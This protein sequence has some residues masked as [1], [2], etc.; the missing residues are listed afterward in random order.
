D[1][2]ALRTAARSAF[3]RADHAG[4]AARHS[5]RIRAAVCA[6]SGTHRTGHR[7]KAAPG[8]KGRTETRN[9]AAASASPAVRPA[10]AQAAR[11]PERQEEAALG[12]G[13]GDVE[14]VGNWLRR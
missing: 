2:L 4:A 1:A 11:V 7:I 13:V 6:T 14:L 8:A 3:H 5:G 10:S 9:E 12:Q